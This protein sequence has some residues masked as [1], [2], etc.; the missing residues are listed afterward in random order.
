MQSPLDKVTMDRIRAREKAKSDK[1]KED[2]A[3]AKA[4]K[5]VRQY[6][7]AQQKPGYG[8]H[9][10]MLHFD[11]NEVARR[12]SSMHQEAQA[13]RVALEGIEKYLSFLAG[14]ILVAFGSLM[15]FLVTR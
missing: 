15:V 6:S 12:I 7:L 9:L 11:I 1:A 4:E 14:T 13:A 2:K 3:K 5:E 8:S 10:D